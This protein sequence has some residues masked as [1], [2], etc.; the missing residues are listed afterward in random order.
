MLENTLVFGKWCGTAYFYALKPWP[1]KQDDFMQAGCW[2][3]SL[4]GANCLTLPGNFG[5][6]MLVG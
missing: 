6:K 1:T 4:A 3:A 5:G 2:E